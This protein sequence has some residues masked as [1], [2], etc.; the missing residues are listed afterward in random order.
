[1]VLSIF[2]SIFV[3]HKTDRDMNKGVWVKTNDYYNRA[4]VKCDVYSIKVTKKRTV[5]LQDSENFNFTFSCGANSDYS[6]SGCFYGT[7]IKT[8]DQAMEYLNKFIPL[9]FND[10]K[11]DERK[12]LRESIKK[13]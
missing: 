4:V 6:F 11:F 10:N 13:I 2:I 3:I 1:M 5:Y 12:E 7:T 8:L 9:H